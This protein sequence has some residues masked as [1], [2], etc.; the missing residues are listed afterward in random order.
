MHFPQILSEAAIPQM[1]LI[2]SVQHVN[3]SANNQNNCFQ[4]KEHFK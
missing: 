1:H 4:I 2:K 3:I